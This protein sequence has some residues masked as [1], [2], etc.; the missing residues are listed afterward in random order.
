MRKLY[1]AEARTIPSQP[2]ILYHKFPAP[3]RCYF[4]THFCVT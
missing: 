1:G 3:Y 2:R 4:Y